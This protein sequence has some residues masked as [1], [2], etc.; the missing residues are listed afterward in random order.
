MGQAF[1]L[2]PKGITDT[3]PGVSGGITQIGG[4]FTKLIPAASGLISKIGPI[5]GKIGTVIFSPKGAIIAAIIAAVALIV[6]NWD[7]IKEAAGKLKDWVVEKWEGIKEKT[8]E[9][10]EISAI[11]LEV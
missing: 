1:G 8:S 2:L 3:A 10:W 11:N 7:K 5:L 9:I 4:L 6:L